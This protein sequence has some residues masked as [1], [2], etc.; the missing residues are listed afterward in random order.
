MIKVASDFSVPHN[1]F[2][3]ILQS[4]ERASREMEKITGEKVSSALWGHMGDQHLHWNALPTDE[5]S[6]DK[7]MDLYRDLAQQ[8]LVRGGT[9]SAEHGMGKKQIFEGEPLLK[10]Q[11]AEGFD[12]AKY[13]I[14]KVNPGQLLNR[15]NIIGV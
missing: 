6:Y 5:S 14:Q 8:V 7:A 9:L 15:G 1:Y 12:Y 2:F 13:L 4:Y 3:Q 11:F 10:T